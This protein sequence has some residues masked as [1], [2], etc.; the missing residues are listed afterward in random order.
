MEYRPRNTASACVDRCE[1]GCLNAASSAAK[2][3]GLGEKFRT[4]G[5]PIYFIPPL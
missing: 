4:L 5:H 1:V 2:F 3:G